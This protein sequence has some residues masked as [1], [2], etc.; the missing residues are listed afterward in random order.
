MKNWK[1]QKMFSLHFKVTLTLM[2]TACA[3]RLMPQASVAVHTSTLT[4]PSANSRST[5]FLSLRSMPAW[6]MLKP[7]A[8]RS[9]SCLLRDLST[10]R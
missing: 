10:C 3:G 8:K 6:W 5:R 9:R 7:S 2:M 4:S 1:K